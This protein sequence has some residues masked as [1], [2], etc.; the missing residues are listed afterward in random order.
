MSRKC[1]IGV[2]KVS[3]GCVKVLNRVKVKVRRDPFGS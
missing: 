2:Q 3:R 1:L